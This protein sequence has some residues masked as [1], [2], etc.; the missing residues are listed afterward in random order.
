MARKFFVPAALLAALFLPVF[1]RYC[2]WPD[3][4][5]GTDH[6]SHIVFI[7]GNAILPY[8]FFRWTVLAL[9]LGEDRHLGPAAAAAVTLA[10]AVTAGLSGLYLSARSNRSTPLVTA[11]C[12]LLALA[13]PLPSWYQLEHILRRVADLTWEPGNGLYRGQ[14]TPNVWHNPT[15]IFAMQFTVGLFWVSARALTDLRL[16]VAAAVGVMMVLALLAKPN[17]VLALAPCLGLALLAQPLPVVPK[18]L[19]LVATFFLPVAV[20]M[21]QAAILVGPKKTIGEEMVVAPYALWSQYSDNIPGSA[22]AGIVFP[23]SVVLLYAGRFREEPDLKLAWAVLGM[24]V[25]QFALLAEA[26]ERFLA[27]NWGWGMIFADHVL[28]LAS[29]EFLLRQRTHWKQLVCLGFLLLHAV[30]GSANLAR[31]MRDPALSVFF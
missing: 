16:K 5:G 8:P 22:L 25:L 2:V 29:C 19:R 20:L 12:V 18:T 27:G 11:L 7:R 31:C 6:S 24:A 26:G 15:T 30:S 10:T 9:A 21:A 13:M 4:P 3:R 14:I 23:L 1:W 17:Y 28:F